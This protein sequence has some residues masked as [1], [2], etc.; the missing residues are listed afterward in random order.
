[1]TKKVH[2]TGKAVERIEVT[3][4]AMRRIEPSELAEVLG[5]EPCGERVAGDLDPIALAQLG[6][7]LIKRLRSSG[8]RPT[9][10]DAS[11]RCKVP[12][13]REDIKALEEIVTEIER[14]TGTRPSLGQI[15]S[16]ILRTHLDL[17]TRR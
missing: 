5:A 10:Q 13:S 11:E 2:I 16:V 3:G 8:G 15:A 6:N 4:R 7:E 17:L 9:L 12:L 14:S 1:M